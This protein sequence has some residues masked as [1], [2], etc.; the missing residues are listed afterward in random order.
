MLT[1]TLPLLPPNARILSAHLAVAV[2]D[3]HL[4]VFNASGPINRCALD[5]R[6]GLRLLAGTLNSLKLAGLSALGEA[7]GMDPSTVYRCRKRLEAGGTEGVLSRRRGPKGAHKITPEVAA[8]LQGYLDEGWSR[9]RAAGEVGLSEGAVRAAI[10]RGQLRDKDQKP[11]RVAASGED[12]RVALSGPGERATEDQRCEQGVAVKRTAERALASLGKLSEAPSVLTPAEAVPGAGVLLALP[13]LLDQG[14]IEVGR[15]VYGGLRNGY[16]GLRSVLL[17]FAFMALLRIK[18]AE[19]LKTWAPGELGLL[20]GLDRA[21]VVETLRRKL[22]EMGRR[23]LARRFNQRLTERWARSEPELLGLLYY[24]GHVRPYHGKHALPKHHVQRRGRPMPAVQDFH[25]NNS[26]SDPLFH[27]TAE[28]TEGLLTML[29]EHLLPQTRQLVGSRRRV[30]VVFDREGWS[31]ER[32]A[33]WKQEGFDV[34]TYRKGKQTRWQERFF[35]NRTVQIDGRPTTYRLAER[36]VKLSNGLMVREV[37]RLSEDGHQTA[38]ITTNGSLSTIQIAHRMFS[39]WKQENFFRYMRQEFAID[40]LST[41]A[42]ISADPGRAVTNPARKKLEKELKT[43]RASRRRLL[44][45]LLELK[46]G[47]TVSAQGQT[48]TEQ[49][50]EAL[51][52]KHEDRIDRLK[53]RIQKLPRQVRLDQIRNPEQIVRLEPERKLLTDAFK[54]IAYRAESALTTLVA[55]CFAR[56][57]DEAR[58]FLQTVFGATADLIPDEADGVLTVRF[59]GL[60]TPRATRALRALCEVVNPTQT[61][62]PG[63]RLRLYFEAP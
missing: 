45:R 4:V 14:L 60:S 58:T 55:P 51:I 62:Y 44:D 40:H 31:P 48:L 3:E 50:L 6:E 37:R 27:V 19:Q 24:D 28:A 10:R 35:R 22:G 59:H 16:Y 2:E 61:R 9:Q 30:T 56:H 12:A 43:Q 5:D 52:R 8:R 34:L 7:F 38:V 13:A 23:G 32:F 54:M 63:T 18:S 17:T 20:L 39:R 33:R 53:A 21:P 11:E 46:P 42:T 47:Q 29:E 1:P 36:R 49:E 41:R 57:E 25:V 15:Q 26:R